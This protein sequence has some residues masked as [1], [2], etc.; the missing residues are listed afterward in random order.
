MEKLSLEAKRIMIER[1]EKDNIIALATMEGDI[2]YVRNVNAFYEDGAFYVITYALSNK[3]KQ[4]EKNH[5][6]AIAGD[7]FTAH[8][9]GINL[10]Y[11]GKTE[12][13]DIAAKLKKAFYTWIDNGHNNFD[14]L[15]I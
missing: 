5:T 3:M 11:F 14:C 9:R 8:G 7:W 4:I 13:K 2:T 6:V 12:N 1:F 10:G 15:S